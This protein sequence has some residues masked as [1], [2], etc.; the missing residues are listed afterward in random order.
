[1]LLALQQTDKRGEAIP[2]D[3]LGKAA[4]AMPSSPPPMPTKTAAST[5]GQTCTCTSAKDCWACVMSFV[6]NA[7]SE[8]FQVAALTLMCIGLATLTAL[9]LCV[10]AGT[11]WGMAKTGTA[12]CHAYYE[13]YVWA[14]NRA[15][16]YRDGV[17][18]VQDADNP[19]I[20]GVG[21]NGGGG[22]CSAGD[23]PIDAE[24]A[25]AHV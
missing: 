4:A 15:Q 18:A 21:G 19:P 22:Y 25:A 7:G 9:G 14:T 24:D 6:A 3:I 10:L 1:M 13:L 20:V 11:C 23:G 12:M 17:Q 16:M 5:S 2:V 8:F